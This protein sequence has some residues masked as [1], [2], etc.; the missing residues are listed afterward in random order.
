M[1]SAPSRSPA[2]ICSDELSDAVGKSL[3][4]HEPALRHLPI[5]IRFR[6][7]GALRAWGTV[8]DQAGDAGRRALR[9]LAKPRGDIV[10]AIA[11]LIACTSV[12]M[13]V[14][15]EQTHRDDWL[16]VLYMATYHLAF[17][18]RNGALYEPTL[19]LRGL[20]S[21]TDLTRELPFHALTLPCPTLCVIQPP[22]RRNNDTD[23]IIVF[24]QDT[25]LDQAPARRSL[26]FIAW[27]DAD[28]G[29]VADE[30]T[31]LVEDEDASLLGRYQSLVNKPEEVSTEWFK[32]PKATLEDSVTNWPID[33]DYLTKVLMYLNLDAAQVSQDMPYSAAPKE[34]T[35]LGR[36]KREIR[37]AEIERLYDRYIVGPAT[38]R[39]TTIG[40][41]G[42]HPDTGHELAAHWRRGHFR[43]QPHGPQ[44]A[45]RKVMFIAPTIVR[46]D[47]L[48]SIIATS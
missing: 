4:L 17:W 27:R 31:L 15:W 44:A 47:R 37:L 13:K 18:M 12:H 2:I 8:I 48:E 5:P 29:P 25:A 24:E 39:E 6:A 19:P 38:W 10:D 42:E 35:G 40:A 21:S 3:A 28:H 30:L 20:L 23:C 34:F 32:S 16:S 33:L 46:A 9:A 11:A 26:T 41:D 14:P 36:R 7:T 22:Q 43:L 45:L 1:R